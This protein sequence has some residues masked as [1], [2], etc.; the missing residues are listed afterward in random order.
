[1]LKILPLIVEGII[2][3]T[4]IFLHPLITLLYGPLAWFIV[5]GMNHPYYIF[6]ML[7]FAL[8]NILYLLNPHESFVDTITLFHFQ[9]VSNVEY[10]DSSLWI[11]ITCG[12]AMG[13]WGFFLYLILEK[14]SRIPPKQQIIPEYPVM[15]FTGVPNGGGGNMLPPVRRPVAKQ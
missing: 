11:L 4:S 3:G 12:I 6:G 14:I 7:Y 2:I 10:K 5:V 1:L 8:L 9:G 15:K 13:F